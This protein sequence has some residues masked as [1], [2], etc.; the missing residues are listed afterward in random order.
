MKERVHGAWGGVKAAWLLVCATALGAHED[1]AGKAEVTLVQFV[2]LC[3]QGKGPTP[4]GGCPC[5]ATSPAAS[6]GDAFRDLPLPL[7]SLLMLTVM[8]CGFC[9]ACGAGPRAWPW[10]KESAV[11]AGQRFPAA[12]SL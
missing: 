4:P 11:T 8:S 1:T 3:C 2:S 10:G 6:R 5:G 9:V 12:S 7:L